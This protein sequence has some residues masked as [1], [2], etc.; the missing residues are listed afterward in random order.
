MAMPETR[1]GMLPDVGATN[2][3]GKMPLDMELYVGLTGAMLSGADAVACG[4][5][6]I[7][8]P[9][10]WLCDF[11]R[12][13]TLHWDGR[14]E[15]ID[16]LRRAFVP[17]ANTEVHPQLEAH[18]EQIRAHFS[19]AGGIESIVR[20]LQQDTPTDWSTATLANLT[21]NSPCMLEVTYHALL[22]GRQ[23]ALADCFRME[24]GIVHPAISEAIS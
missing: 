24:L 11:A 9:S 10:P 22:R 12:L 13:E 18:R 1:I 3:M 7:C 8:V 23:L 6:D 19:A 21:S 14:E 4:L 20:S 2:F 17:P 15:A 16:S 5:A